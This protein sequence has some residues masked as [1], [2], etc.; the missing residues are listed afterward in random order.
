[1]A[2]GYA[3]ITIVI[4]LSSVILCFFITLCRMVYLAYFW[5]GGA[6]TTQAK[7]NIEPS[8]VVLY[9]PYRP[10]DVLLGNQDQISKIVFVLQSSETS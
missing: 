4:I 1:M 5:N 8:K 10:L 3:G 7:C 9:E 6:E 2:D